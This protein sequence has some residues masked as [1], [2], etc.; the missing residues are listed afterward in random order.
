MSRLPKRKIPNGCTAYR[1]QGGQSMQEPPWM[2]RTEEEYRQQLAEDA[3]PQPDE[4]V[5]LQQ[6]I[7]FQ[8]QSIVEHK[9][10]LDRQTAR[11]IYL[12]RLLD[13]AY[14][15][16]HNPYTQQ[17]DPL[18]AT[19][20]DTIIREVEHA[21]QHLNDEDEPERAQLPCASCDGDGCPNCARRHSL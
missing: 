11:V 3:G 13:R 9:T 16:L 5:R 1:Q 7:D 14:P 4:M 19:T 15:L 8:E 20:Y 6:T 10:W 12:E 18:L 17:S 21:I 2:P